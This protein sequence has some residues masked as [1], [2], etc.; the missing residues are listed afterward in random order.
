MEGYAGGTIGL[1]SSDKIYSI[2]AKKLGL[3]QASPKFCTKSSDS[4]WAY[5][6]VPIFRRLRRHLHVFVCILPIIRLLKVFCPTEGVC[7][8]CGTI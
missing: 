3:P 1:K 4:G 2:L 6:K 5:E 8:V 7:D